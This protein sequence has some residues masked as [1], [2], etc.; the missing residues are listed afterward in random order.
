MTNKKIQLS[1]FSL[2]SFLAIALVALLPSCT[3]DD[4][5]FDVIESPVLAL[6]EEDIDTDGMLNMTATFY[7][8]DKSGILDQNVGIDS[9]LI[10]G[11]VLEV[12]INE[13]VK[14]GEVTT[15]SAGKAVFSKS[16]GDLNGAS[17]LEWVGN[18]EGTPFRIYRNF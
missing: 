10:T 17:R 18:Y 4:L 3:S 7:E 9:T 11:L 6:F 5:A 2:L 8:L 16:L 15:D 14:V 1:T 13:T 12:F